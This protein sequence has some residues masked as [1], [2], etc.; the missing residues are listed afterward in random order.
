MQELE[1]FVLAENKDSLVKLWTESGNDSKQYLALMYTLNKKGISGLS[2]KETDLIK[3]WSER[4]RYGEYLNPVL[5]YCLSM[6]ESEKNPKKRMDL[7][8]EFNNQFM[9][10]SFNDERVRKGVIAEPSNQIDTQKKSGKGKQSGGS[11]TK[12]SLS[13]ED[14]TELSTA[15]LLKN[16]QEDESWYNFELE[17]ADLAFIKKIDLANVKTASRIDAALTRFSDFGFNKVLNIYRR[18]SIVC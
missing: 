7:M 17:T 10:Y 5:K 8:K 3:N 9:H 16:I 11:Q 18:T 15:Q 4:R 12:T 2:E 6:I 14:L 1:E 13:A